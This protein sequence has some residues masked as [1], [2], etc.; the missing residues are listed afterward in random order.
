MLSVTRTAFDGA[1]LSVPQV[2]QR[3][4]R[5]YVAIRTSGAMTDLPSF[6]PPLFPQL[7]AWMIQ[8]SVP[9]GGEA[10]F[11][12][13]QFGGDGSVELDV[14]MTTMAPFAT[15]PP[16][17]ADMLPAGRY[18]TATFTGPYDR[19]HDAF[20]MLE[21]WLGGRGLTPEGAY[22]PA[23]AKPACQ[24]EFYRITPTQTSNPAEWETDIELKLAD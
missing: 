21:G 2:V 17:T 10:F 13:R 18:A 11:R 8:E 4:A 22:G 15:Q 14:G 9:S 24:V 5:H 20:C 3:K 16:A 12:Y 1:H 23:G 7:H 6:A 19:L